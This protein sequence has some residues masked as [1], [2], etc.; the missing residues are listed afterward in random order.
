MAV[1][2]LARAIAVVALLAT[3]A[4]AQPAG[5]TSVVLRDGNAAAG[6]GDWVRVWG[7]VEPLL[8]GQLAPADLAEAH[9]LAG[10]ATYFQQ[11]TG[12][13]EQHFLAYLKLDLDGRLDPALYPPEV[14]TFFQDVQTRHAGELRALRPRQRRHFVLNLIPPL[15]QFQNG[16]RT[17]GYAIAGLLGVF[18]IGNVTSYLVLRSWCTRVT[19]DLGDSATCDASKDRSRSASQ[20]R[21][22]NI[23]TGLGLIATY[24]YGVYDGVT[25]YR[26]RSREQAIEPF[27]TPTAGGG[28]FGI[29]GSF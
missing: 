18:A 16:A 14:V 25:G 27:A 28:V 11:R 8:H 20:L 4:S 24:M 22:L 19:G 13:A 26:R 21:S 5:S 10:L 1:T 12:E 29:A 23:A 17:K 15:G 3:V 9:R 6:A 7:L 2:G